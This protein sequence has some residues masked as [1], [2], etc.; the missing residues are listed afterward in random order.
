MKRIFNPPSPATCG[1]EASARFFCRSG[2]KEST[3]VSPWSFNNIRGL[4][5]VEVLLSTLLMSLVFLAVSALYVS[6]QRLFFAANDKI[7]ISYELQYAID[8]IYKNT[9]RA[10]GD[11]ASPAIDVSVADTLDLNINNNDP[12]TQ[13]NYRDTVTYSYKKQGNE[14]QFYNGSSW[15]SLVPKI[16]VTDVDFSLS[17]NLLTISLTGSYK[18]QTLTFYAACYPRLASFH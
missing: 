11:E 1:G 16:Q 5:L 10:I 8:H 6:S 13:S 15:E 2:K 4:T 9:M 14:L 18:D 12:L 17:E 3:G 7:I